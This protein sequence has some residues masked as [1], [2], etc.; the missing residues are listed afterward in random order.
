MMLRQI[1]REGRVEEALPKLK[2]HL[3]VMQR[4]L[5]R[6][7]WSRLIDGKVRDNSKTVGGGQSRSAMHGTSEP[8][9]RRF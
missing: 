3:A 1:L 8:R 6:D 7:C 2:G 9:C 4:E 5:I